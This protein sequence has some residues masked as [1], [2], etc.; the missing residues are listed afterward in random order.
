MAE[1]SAVNR[2]V[3]GSSPTIPATCKCL[4]Y[5]HTSFHGK[6]ERRLAART[7]EYLLSSEIQTAIEMGAIGRA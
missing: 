6:A 3:V 1:L 5:L 4:L 7:D 2:S